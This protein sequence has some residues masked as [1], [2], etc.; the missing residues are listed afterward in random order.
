MELLSPLINSHARFS[1][2]S[3]VRFSLRRFLTA[4]FD[5]LDA[6][7]SPTTMVTRRTSRLL[8]LAIVFVFAVILI[9]PSDTFIGFGLL[10]SSLRFQKSTF[11][12]SKV[13]Q[14]HPLDTL[15]QI[16]R[17]K[18]KDLPPLQH[19]FSQSYQASTETERRRQAVHDAFVQSWSSYKEHAWLHDELMPV[20]GG[21]KNPFGGWA[22]TLVDS[23]DSLWIMGLK[24]EFYQAAGAATRINWNVTKETGVNLFEITIRHL[25][26]LLS[27]Y[28]LSGERALLLKAQELGEMLYMA[29]DTPNRIP[30]FWF[31]FEDAKAGSQMAGTFDPSAAPASLSMEFTRLAQIT[32]IRKYYDAVDRVRAF[33]ERNQEKSHLPGLWPTMID[34]KHENVRADKQF[35]LGALADSLYEYLLKMYILLDGREEASSYEKMYRRAMD[36]VIEHLLY[37]P[38]LPDSTDILFPGNAYVR[39]GGVETTT[40]AQHLACFAGGMFALG[41]KIFGINEHV[42]IGKRVAR[43][44]AWAYKAFPTG[45]MP[46]RFSLLDCKSP[47]LQECEWDEER[48]RQDGDQSL[49]KGFKHAR[50]P[51]YLLRPEAIESIFILYRITGQEDLREI[52]WD[53]FQSIMKSTKTQFANSAIEDVTVVGETKKE[54][55]MEKY[56]QS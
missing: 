9:R 34:F 3:L 56:M 31:T 24:E 49:P 1:K 27:A 19:N 52:A 43:G 32:G 17:G 22:A 26:G 51:R 16:P 8:V 47:G 11:D 45:L 14:H 53:M 18:P 37:R 42:N 48:W 44:C 54:D 20:S 36:V 30:G 41:G 39:D 15:A 55:S 23:L 35:S 21:H 38:M 25:G 33:L 29:F 50:D 28:E 10:R 12:W 46:E 2:G 6:P 4:L 13:Q 5:S 40:E 7:L